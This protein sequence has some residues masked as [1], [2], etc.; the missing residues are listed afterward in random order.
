MPVIEA[1][2]IYPKE[3][4]KYEVN[5]RPMPNWEYALMYWQV[6]GGVLMEKLDAMTPWHV[7]QTSELK[8]V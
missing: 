3:F 4:P 7:L 8:K 5:D 1:A 2:E 6:Y